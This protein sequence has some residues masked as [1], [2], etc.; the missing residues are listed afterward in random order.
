MKSTLTQQNLSVVLGGKEKKPATMTDVEWGVLDKLSRGAIENYIADEVLINVMQD[1]AKQTWE[2]LEEMF[3]GKS[4]SNKLFLKKE[5][6]NLRMEEEGNLMEHLSS[7]NRCVAD[8]QRMEVNYSTEDKAL[9]FLTSL[10]P[11]YKHFRTTLMFGKSTLNFEEVVQDVMAHHRMSQRSEENSQDVGLF[12][13]NC[14]SKHEGKRN[15]RRNAKSKD[16]EGCFECGS[17]DHWK[18]NC[19]IWKNKMKKSESSANI[20]D[21]DTSDELLTVT[22]ESNREVMENSSCKSSTSS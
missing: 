10:P 11:S 7:F 21:K 1:T 18:W 19:P 3:A 15:N 13:G 14:S 8:L 16:N 17:K 6:L 4:L 20:C 9:M 2:N 22:E 5:L 12:A